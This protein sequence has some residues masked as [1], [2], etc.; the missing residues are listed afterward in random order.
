MSKSIWYVMSQ[1]LSLVCG[2]F[3]T[4]EKAVFVANGRPVQEIPVF[5]GAMTDD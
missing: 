5:E 4:K 1:D 3:G 2:V